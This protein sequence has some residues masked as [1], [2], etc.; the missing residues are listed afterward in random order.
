MFLNFRVVRSLCDHP[1]AGSTRSGYTD[2]YTEVNVTSD[3]CGTGTVLCFTN[4]GDDG[5]VVTYEPV[6]P[7]DYPT[8]D[9]YES[10]DLAAGCPVSSIVNFGGIVGGCV[11]LLAV[12]A[13]VCCKFC[14]KR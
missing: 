7:S 8:M 14:K 1:K 9:L 4:L 10:L 3:R 6:W 13:G 2:G 12:I 11:A 5:V